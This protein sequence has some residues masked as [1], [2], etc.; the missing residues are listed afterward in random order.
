MLL[1][2]ASD[3]TAKIN[4][5]QAL[6]NTADQT[7]QLATRARQF[8]SASAALERLRKT[9]DALSKAGIVVDFEPKDG[10]DFAE[11]ANLLREEIKADPGRLNDPPFDLKHGFTDRL[12]GI[13]GAGEKAAQA[14]W[15]TYVEKYASFGADDVLNA[16][17]QVAQFKESVSAIRQTRRD[18]AAL[19]A[20]LPSDPVSEVAKLNDLVIRHEE[21]WKKLDTSNIPKS[22]VA[23]IQSAAGGLGKL[24]DFTPEVRSW[25]EDRNLLDAFRVKLR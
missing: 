18:V 2:R 10:R 24:S 12:L 15:K 17:A 14:A 8:V 19:A 5:Y 20:D 22:V 25:L 16:L 23:F 21:A 1:D 11:K 7:E 3:L 4:A 6:K 13:A 9:L